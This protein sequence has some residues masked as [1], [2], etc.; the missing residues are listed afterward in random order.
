MYFSQFFSI[1]LWI[2]NAQEKRITDSESSW[3]TLSSV[4]LLYSKSLYL[5]FYSHSKR[6]RKCTVVGTFLTEVRGL[7]IL[8]DY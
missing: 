3:K 8:I 4:R 2:K 7:I 5:F 1:I 6:V